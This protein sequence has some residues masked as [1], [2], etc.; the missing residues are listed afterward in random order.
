MDSHGSETEKLEVWQTDDVAP[1]RNLF[2]CLFII[3]YLPSLAYISR[4]IIAFGRKTFPSFFS[5]RISGAAPVS[6]SICVTC[7]LATV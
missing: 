6:Q 7:C 2:V 5:V 4:T 3:T 1:D